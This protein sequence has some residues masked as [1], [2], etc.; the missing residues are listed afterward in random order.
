MNYHQ[1]SAF[2][3]LVPAD[4][5]YLMCAV[6][7]QMLRI[8]HMD[9]ITPGLAQML[10]EMTN[11]DQAGATM[12]MGMAAMRGGISHRRSLLSIL[13]GWMGLHFGGLDGAAYYSTLK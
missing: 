1:S 12:L 6:E 3:G 2:V 5:P 10:G 11:L 4:A 7:L 13:A 8:S 9:T